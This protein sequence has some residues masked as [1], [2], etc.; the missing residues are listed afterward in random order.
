MAS[1]GSTFAS[2][3]PFGLLLRQLRKR[4]GMTQRDLAAALGYSD[5]LISGLEKGQRLPD[6]EAVIQ[7]FIPALGLQD[8][9]RSAT[10]LIESAAFA[11]GQTL[12]ATTAAAHLHQ[13]PETTPDGATAHRLPAL[14]IT[15]VGRDELVYQ[16]GK[17]L[18]GHQGR[19]L[20]LVGPPGVGKTTLA[21]AVGEHVQRHYRDGACFVPLAAVNDAAMMAAAIVATVAPDDASNKPSQN[22]LVEL[23][24][25]QTLL[26]VLDNLEQIAD[27]A[28]LIAALL[29]ECAGVTIL[30][31]S[32]ERLH[33]RAEQRSLV[34]P[35]DLDAAVELFVQ[36]AQAVYGDF[37]LTQQN[38]PTL[39]AICTR[40]DCLPLALELCAGQIQIF[41]SAELLAQLQARPLDLLVDGAQDLPA[42]QHTLRTTIQ[43]SYELLQPEEQLLL[44]RL[45]V[46][47]GGFDLAVVEMLGV[48]RLERRDW[49]LESNGGESPISTLQSLL[50]KSLVRTETLATGEQRFSLLETIREFALEQLRLHEEDEAAR[51]WHYAHYLARFRT[52]DQHLRGPEA[53]V[54]FARLH[55]EFDNLRA[56]MRWTLDQECYEDTTWLILAANWY[57]H[58]Q[59]HWYEQLGWIQEVLPHRHRFAPLLRLGLLIR[60]YSVA[61][62]LA[63]DQNMHRYWN[64]LIEL[65]ESCPVKLLQTAAWVWVARAATDF[66]QATV[67]WQK[68]ITFARAAQGPP[69]IGN[70]FG[71]ISDQ[72]FM[73]SATVGTYAAR[74]I[75]QGDFAQAE[76]LARE[77]LAASEARGYVSGT[78]ATLGTM[79]RLALLQGDLPQAHTLLQRAVTTIK[80]SIHLSVLAKIQPLLALVILY[81]NDTS[82]ARHLLMESLALW[83]TIG[84]KQYLAQVS[85]YLAETA[86]WEGQL[87][88]AEAW[89]AQAL[90]YQVDPRRLGMALING[91][92]IAARLAVA[93]QSIQKAATLFGAAEQVRADAR[94]TL[95][96]PVR[97]QVD[98]DLATV[99]TALAPAA[100]AAAFAAG[101]QLSPAQA[102]TTLLAAPAP[103]TP[104]N[105]V[106]AP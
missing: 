56:A 18:R 97:I 77:A 45:G 63:H 101:R 46:F 8:D 30:A 35:L 99:Q 34:P 88:E 42:H 16:L 55:P 10:K 69:E 31:T 2:T 48:W 71:V 78:G 21:L 65:A 73:L 27:A 39:A 47:V 32:R 100:F 67:A 57:G 17:R 60:F 84:E 96:A 14:P 83:R 29:A 22:R 94:R 61:G 43:R 3:S 20:T 12:P 36:R 95:V 9:P 54:W 52:A 11:R 5:S 6:L 24:R 50:V 25:R 74:L 28:S 72:G 15:L 19:L 4:A 53:A 91:L 33:L 13:A 58:I 68:A 64:E 51:Q 80:S 92:L 103:A 23:L 26:L 44:R 79:G 82:D 66:A 62:P 70:E 49:R 37:R 1:R 105:L 93:R 75:E 59:G 106:S 41:P 38:Q 89:L 40:L 85:I 87:A 90:G 104:D 76:A 86:L 98:A 7:R 81:Q 102:V